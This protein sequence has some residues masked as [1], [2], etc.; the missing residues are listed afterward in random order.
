MHVGAGDRVPGCTG[1]F[2]V[3]RE[4]RTSGRRANDGS[5]LRAA[6]RIGAVKGPEVVGLRGAR[7]KRAVVHQA[8]EIRDAEGAGKE[9]RFVVARRG[10]SSD[11]VDRADRV[12][13]LALRELRLAHE[14]VQVLYEERKQFAGA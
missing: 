9:H 14:G 11:R 5:A 12:L 2:S 4:R 7:T 1:Y 10:L 3:E 13:E 8:D 6:R